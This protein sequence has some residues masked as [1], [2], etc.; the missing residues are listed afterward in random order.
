MRVS[1]SPYAYS[2]RLCRRLWKTDL[3]S[4]S[5]EKLRPGCWMGTAFERCSSFVVGGTTQ[6]LLR[7]R[8]CHKIQWSKMELAVDAGR[9]QLLP[10]RK[11]ETCLTGEFG[12]EESD[13]LSN[14]GPVEY[15]VVLGD[16]EG[17]CKRRLPAI[18]MKR[19]N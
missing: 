7:Y 5:L 16:R 9:C 12:F 14:D 2:K 4:S 17:D 19:S 11:W 13:V 6:A 18:L 8:T 15:V 1:N 10:E 3:T